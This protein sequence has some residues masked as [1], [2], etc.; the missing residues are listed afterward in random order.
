M[1]L[2]FEISYNQ[3]D[4][5]LRLFSLTVSLCIRMVKQTKLLNYKPKEKNMKKKVLL[6]TLLVVAIVASCFAFTACNK[7]KGDGDKGVKVAMITDYGDITDQSFNQTTYEA[8]KAYCGA[9]NI[10][11]KYYKPTGDSTEARVASVNAAIAE[12]YTII[13]M[14]GYAFGGTI[15]EVADNNP[16]IKFVAL[17][18]ARGDLLEAKYGKEYDYNPDNPKWTYQL[19][20]NVT[21][22]VYQEEISGYMAG[23][24]AVKEGYK[25][26]GFLGG[27]AVPAVIRFGY[28]FVQ[29]VNAAA[30]ELGIANE[31]S[32]NYVY[33]GKFQGSP[34]ITA[35]MDTWY[36][37]GTEVVFA[38]GGGIFTSA[39]EA[40]TKAGVNGKVI[41]VDTDQSYNINGKY[42]AGLCITS[43]MK[44]LAP[45]V[46]TIL[47]DIFAGKWEN[48]AGRINK[49]GMVSGTD[50][51]L[52]YVQLP[53]ATWSMKNFT[54]EDYA[55][56]VGKIFDGTIKISDAID[57]MPTT[58]ITVT[59]QA[60]IH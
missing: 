34:E 39:C 25:K 54:K 24:A 19:P 35:A 44:G 3:I 27:M 49:L 43:A 21:C 14:P 9:N 55:T 29:G 5:R 32:V 4:K 2:F 28:G 45:T 18:V 58:T 33:G 10:K 42:G 15:V 8:C 50:A 22:F 7:N 46:N 13:V 30:V 26:L 60:N 36:Q 48:Y 56:L 57:K 38:C 59:T 23:Y 51:S 47:T 52:N 41:G 53:T 11:F 40:A 16:E 6:V 31:V 37:G 17:D 20:S 1:T 12:G